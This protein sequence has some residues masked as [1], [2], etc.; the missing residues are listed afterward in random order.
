MYPL[1]YIHIYTNTYIDIYIYTF[2]YIHLYIHIYIYTYIHIYTYIYI[3]IYT[4]IHIYIYICIYIYSSCLTAACR[5]TVQKMD[6]NPN[7]TDCMSEHYLSLLF[8]HLCNCETTFVGSKCS[9][10]SILWSS[11]SVVLPRGF[12]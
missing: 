9:I 11:E 4:Y 2:T 12:R 1:Y 6:L 7:S 10:P 8:R 3:Y 5:D